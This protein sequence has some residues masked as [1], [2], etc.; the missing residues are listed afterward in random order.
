[1]ISIMF[2]LKITI[3]TVV[4]LESDM[5]IYALERMEEMIRTKYHII[6]GHL[7]RGFKIIWNHGA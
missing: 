7:Q 3:F 4:S 2:S 1:M 5:W 6:E